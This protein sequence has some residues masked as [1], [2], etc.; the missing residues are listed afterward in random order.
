MGKI[1]HYRIWSLRLL[2]SI[3][4]CFFFP[5][6][7]STKTKPQTIP[8]LLHLCRAELAAQGTTT[9]CE[10]AVTAKHGAST[11]IWCKQCVMPAHTQ[12]DPAPGSLV[13]DSGSNILFFLEWQILCTFTEYKTHFKSS[14]NGDLRGLVHNGQCNARYHHHLLRSEWCLATLLQMSL[15]QKW[16]S[17]AGW[18]KV[19][20][21]CKEWPIFLSD[22]V[23]PGNLLN[24]LLPNLPYHQNKTTRTQWA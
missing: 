10:N 7:H 20:M 13:Q 24:E 18:A 21:S 5:S 12:S 4:L 1:S 17:T 23:Y 22:R 14:I 8:P 3:I 9:V 6:T 16:S 11:A 15:S 2:S 19:P